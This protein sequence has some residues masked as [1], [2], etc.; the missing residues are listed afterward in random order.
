M[1]PNRV[2]LLRSAIG[3]IRRLEAQYISFREKEPHPIFPMEEYHHGILLL[4][5]VIRAHQVIK[6]AEN[7]LREEGVMTNQDD[8]GKLI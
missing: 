7:Q 5:D 3:Y 2:V 8:V 6:D 4:Q 1:E